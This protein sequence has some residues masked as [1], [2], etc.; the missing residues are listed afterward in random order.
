MT[1]LLFREDA[2][3]RECEALVVSV[4]G[5]RV[6]TD[7]TVFYARAGGQPGDTGVLRAADGGELRV[8]DTVYDRAAGG[9]AHLVEGPAADLARPGARV[10]LAIDWGRRHRIMCTHTSLHLL[11]AAADA[12]VTSG[13]MHE[14]RGRI[15]FDLPDPPDRQAIEDRINEWRERDLPV[16][17]REVD[18]EE[19]DRNPALVRTV[20][21]RPPR[22][23]GKV[24]LVEIPGVDL[25]ACGGT[26]VRSTGEIAPVR[27]TDV[28]KKGRR[29]RRIEI[30]VGPPPG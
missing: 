14:G 3:L 21:V 22:G 1:R 11:C 20:A 12:P 10:S 23:T 24:R 15:D 26:H 5:D 27:I 7:A 9:V 25:Q 2:Y 30:A 6:V 18:E 19:L 16:S 29:N 13:N 17:A 28:S 8:V 4:D